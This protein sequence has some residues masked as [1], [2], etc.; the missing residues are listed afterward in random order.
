MTGPG[1]DIPLPLQGGSSG[2]PWAQ[3]DLLPRGRMDPLDPASGVDG[4]VLADTTG[5]SAPGSVRVDD[6]TPAGSAGAWTAHATPPVWPGEV[7]DQ[8]PGAPS[9][10]AAAFGQ[11]LE[12]VLLASCY[13][14][15]LAAAERAGVACLAFASLGS[16]HAEGAFPMER[17]AK[18]ALGHAVGHLARRPPPRCPA[19]VVFFVTPE[20]EAVYRRLVRTRAQWAAGRRRA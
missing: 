17:A 7:P 20:E 9:G 18:I 19:K 1:G 2:G 14:A 3:I 10:D 16:E 13:A 8:A 11:A 6:R 5:G 15:S 12:D 4:I